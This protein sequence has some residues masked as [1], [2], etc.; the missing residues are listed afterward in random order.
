MKIFFDVLQKSSPTSKNSIDSTST[1]L[2]TGY[3]ISN[4]PPLHDAFFSPWNS[5]LV[6]PKR[7][8]LLSNNLQIDELITRRPSFITPTIIPS[9][10]EKLT[11]GSNFQIPSDSISP[12]LASIPEY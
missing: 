2:N 3:P 12:R 6:G 10:I 5:P 1:T 11:L 9:Q 4:I 8:S 7:D